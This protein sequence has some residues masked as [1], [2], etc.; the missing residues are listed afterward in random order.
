MTY[1]AGSA[2]EGW[3]QES[4]RTFQTGRWMNI[5]TALKAGDYVMLQFGTNDSGTV[6]G[7]HVDV[8]DFAVALGEMIDDVEGKQ[9]FR[10]GPAGK[11]ATLAS[12]RMPRRC[13]SSARCAACGS[14][15][16]TRAA[17]SS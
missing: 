14:T 2:Q 15:I 1:E 9:R 12:D 3:G 8:P 5:L 6:Q 16:S 11:Q 13:G 4:V 10:N 7:R 17:W